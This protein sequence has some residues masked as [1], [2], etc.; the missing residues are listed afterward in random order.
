MAARDRF[1]L[2]ITC[3]NCGANGEARVSEDDY[4]FMRSPRFSVDELPAEFEVVKRAAHRQD[5]LLVHT[6][7]KV[8]FTF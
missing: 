8:K 4:P 7:C 1:E 5:V 6:P 3:P 2:N